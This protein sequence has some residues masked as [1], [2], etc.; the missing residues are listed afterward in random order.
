VNQNKDSWDVF[1]PVNLTAFSSKTLVALIFLITAENAGIIFFCL[2]GVHD[3]KA[4]WLCR[5]SA[6][7]NQMQ[8]CT[9]NKSRAQVESFTLLGP[10]GHEERYQ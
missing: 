5:M 6:R 7:S 8:V 2:C 10:G 9:K 4:C 1:L 3:R